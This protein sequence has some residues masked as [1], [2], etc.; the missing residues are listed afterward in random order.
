M[1]G[2]V[3]ALLILTAFIAI[4]YRTRLCAF[5]FGLGWTYLFLIDSA[6]YLNQY[7]AIC[8]VSFA[9]TLVHADRSFSVDAALKRTRATTISAWNLWIFQFQIALIYIY[10]GI[11]KFESGWLNARP[12]LTWLPE[13]AEWYGYFLAYGGLLFDLI[14]VPLLMWR[15]TRIFAIPCLIFFHVHNE[16]TFDIGIFAFLMFASTILFFE[17]DWIRK[18]RFVDVPKRIMDT[19]LPSFSMQNLT[20]GFLATFV[21][22]QLVVP[23]RHFVYEGRSSW[24]EEGRRFGWQMMLR[25]KESSTSFVVRVP[26]TDHQFSVKLASYLSPLQIQN[27]GREPRLLAQFGRFIH[28]KYVSHNDRNAEIYAHAFVSL[29][30]RPF[31]PIVDPTVNLATTKES[32]T[33]AADWTVALNQL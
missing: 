2:F 6:Y 25:T 11:V 18:W 22:I 31:Q 15:K 21:F 30:G 9:L 14:I 5:L 33:T 13:R 20:M 8:I 16:A 19:Q 4:G 1:Y 17:P 12:L 28:K 32:M 23:L 7:Y 27:M 10:A 24:T 26:E 29:N 3:I